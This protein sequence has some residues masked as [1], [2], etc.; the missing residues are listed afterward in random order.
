MSFL[1]VRDAAMAPR[2]GHRVIVLLRARFS[3]TRRVVIEFG[4]WRSGRK[5]RSS[6]PVRVTDHAARKPRFAISTLIEIHLALHVPNI[7]S[8]Q[9]LDS[10][11]SMT[12]AV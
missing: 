1:R 5:G 2:Q 11:A 4:M 9:I 8:P 12:A 3:R 6:G 7:E 10:R